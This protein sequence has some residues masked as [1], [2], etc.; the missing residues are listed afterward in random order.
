MEAG[1]P[2]STS[3]PQAPPRPSSRVLFNK[4]TLACKAPGAQ[5]LPQESPKQ[6]PLGTRE[7]DDLPRVKNLWEAWCPPLSLLSPTLSCFCISSFQ[8]SQSHPP[9]SEN[10][11]PL[12]RPTCPCHR[13]EPARQSLPLCSHVQSKWYFR[14]FRPSATTSAGGSCP[15]C[16]LAGLVAP[17][18]QIHQVEVCLVFFYKTTLASPDPPGTSSSHCLASSL[19]PI[20]R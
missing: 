11:P 18:T 5:M 4:G 17:D 19:L 20:D 16:N 13:V 9:G 7:R 1:R 8:L 10:S 2:P 3:V 12:Y 14:A 15:F 6:S